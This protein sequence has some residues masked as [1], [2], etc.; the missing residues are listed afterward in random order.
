MHCWNTLRRKTI[1]CDRLA[2]KTVLTIR[3]YLLSSGTEKGHKKSLKPLY[4]KEPPSSNLFRI[5]GEGKEAWQGKSSTEVNLRE[6]LGARRT[7]AI[8][9]RTGS[10]ASTLAMSTKGL[11]P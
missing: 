6:I 4:Q 11:V 1:I 10:T 3:Q 5:M 7:Q 8:H 2:N 9:K